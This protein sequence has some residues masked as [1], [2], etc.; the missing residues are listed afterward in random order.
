MPA[1]EIRQLVGEEVWNSYTKITPIRNPWDKMVSLYYWRTRKRTTIDKVRRFLWLK[2]SDDPARKMTFRQH[3][4][5]LNDIGEINIDRDVISLDGGIPDY[6]YIRFENLHEDMKVICDKIGV[7]YIP[8]KLPNKK[9]GVRKKQGYHD[10][11]DEKSKDL[12][13]NAYDLE[14]EK[15]GYS[16]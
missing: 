4:K 3:I 13:A 10:H 5:Y 6:L 9:G 1:E 16:F 14:I 8:E 15:F 12:V 7:P 11:Y 2:W